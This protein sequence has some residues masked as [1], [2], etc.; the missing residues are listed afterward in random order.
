MIRSRPVRSR[1]VRTSSKPVEQR[2]HLSTLVLAVFEQ[3]PAAGPQ[4]PPGLRGRHRTTSRPSTPPNKAT[5]DRAAPPPGRAAPSPRD[6]GRVADHQIHRSEVG[7]I[8]RAQTSATGLRRDRRRCVAPTAAPV[9]LPPPPPRR[10][11]VSMARLSA[12]AALP[13]HRST[14]R[15]KGSCRAMSTGPRSPAAGRTHRADLRSR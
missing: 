5:G 4:Q 1:H 10:L 7:Q 3:H 6:V 8:V 12:I 14:A 13:V 9:G 15:S 2:P 11:R